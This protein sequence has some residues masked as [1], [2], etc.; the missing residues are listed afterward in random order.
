MFT[1]ERSFHLLL[2]QERYV[3]VAV[4]E[5]SLLIEHYESVYHATE[6]REV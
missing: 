2:L 4:V 1:L 6:L 5:T 3:P